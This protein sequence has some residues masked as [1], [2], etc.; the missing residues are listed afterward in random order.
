MR[1]SSVYLVSRPVDL[2]L[3]GGL[4]LAVCGLYRWTHVG[5]LGA[6]LIAGGMLTWSLNWP[7]FAA[8]NFRLYGS[9]NTISQYPIT[10]VVSP[11]VVGFLIIAALHSPLLVTPVLFKLFLVWSPFHYSGQTFG[12]SLLY[13]RKARFE[14]ESW[15]RAA[16]SAF[17]FLTFISES[18]A[19]ETSPLGT[20]Y[21]GVR[22]PT[23]GLPEALPPLLRLAMYL[24]AALTVLGFAVSAIRQRRMPPFPLLLV[25]VTQYVWF[26]VGPGVSGFRELVPAFHSLQYLVIAWAMHARSADTHSASAVGLWKLAPVCRWMCWNLA[27]GVVLFFLLPRLPG[28]LGYGQPMLAAGVVTTGVQV[29]HFFVDGVIWKLRSKAVSSPL[30]DA[31]DAQGNGVL[32]PALE[33]AA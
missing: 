13:A 16:L 8:T 6:R 21:F 27:G 22:L 9:R 11:L 19:A 31:T 23:F 32:A 14:V 28:G 15:C 4:S 20:I 33:L 17:I 7:H 25:P 12:V 24:A 3:L 1:A 26:V 29:H 2:A 30:V 5:D 10:A 18:A